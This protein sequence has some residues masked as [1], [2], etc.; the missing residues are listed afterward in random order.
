MSLGTQGSLFSEQAAEPTLGDL[1]TS[2]SRRPLTEGAWVDLCP[3]WISGADDLFDRLRECVPWRAERRRMYERVVEVPRLVSIHQADLNLVALPE[4]VTF[5][6]AAG[7][8][9]R[10][11]TSFRAV[12]DQGKVAAGQWVA[13]HGCGGVGLAESIFRSLKARE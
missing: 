12:V 4:T 10:F 8:G 6:T 13:V 1:S 9:C 7:L 3:G 5:A 11:V 2:I